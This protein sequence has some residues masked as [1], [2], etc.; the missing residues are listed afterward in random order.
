M[1]KPETKNSEDLAE[2]T[3]NGEGVPIIAGA[4][5]KVRQ[6]A[7]DYLQFGNDIAE[8]QRQHPF[9]TRVQIRKAISYY[10]DHK[11]LIDAEIEESAKEYDELHRK[12][13]TSPIRQKLG[14]RASPSCLLVSFVDRGRLTGIAICASPR[15]RQMASAQRKRLARSLCS[16][17]EAAGNSPPF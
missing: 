7:V 14:S 10:L 1:A 4:N 17:T 15:G 12:S 2:I 11:D 13:A 6:I 3:V 9:L 16:G 5:F 8:I